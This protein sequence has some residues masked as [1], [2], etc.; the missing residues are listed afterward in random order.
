MDITVRRSL[1]VMDGKIRRTEGYV[2]VSDTSSY[3][4]S[5]SD[6]SQWICADPINV[7]NLSSYII[8]QIPKPSDLTNT[9]S[10]TVT[11]MLESVKM[12]SLADNQI[13]LSNMPTELLSEFCTHLPFLSVIA[14][15]KTCKVIRARVISSLTQRFW[16]TRLQAGEVLP[17]LLPGEFDGEEASASSNC[18]WEKGL[19]ALIAMARDIGPHE[20]RYEE[21]TLPG[22]RPIGLENRWRIWKILKGIG[23]DGEE[24]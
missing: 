7:P 2:S 18:D 22:A 14:L 6:P 9:T 15:R 13:C 16:R 12:F 17:W 19:K 21:V 8:S 10:T 4:I 20:S 24:L 1:G 23:S 5:S 11:D 3:T